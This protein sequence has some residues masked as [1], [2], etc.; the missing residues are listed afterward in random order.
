MIGN[1]RDQT[2][3]IVLLCRRCETQN[4]SLKP[5][6]TMFEY[7]HSLRKFPSFQRKRIQLFFKT[8]FR[9]KLARISPS[10]TVHEMRTRASDSLNQFRFLSTVWWW[11]HPMVRGC[12]YANTDNNKWENNSGTTLIKSFNRRI[13]MFTRWLH[14]I[15]L[16]AITVKVTSD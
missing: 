4:L 8:D 6:R 7:P 15:R 9:S 11:L 1:V 12:Y 16:Y 14:V 13:F 10:I 3:R 5:P 2:H